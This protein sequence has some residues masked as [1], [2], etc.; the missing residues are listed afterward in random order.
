VPVEQ[1][2]IQPDFLWVRAN[3]D[4]IRFHDR[5][6]KPTAILTLTPR[7]SLVFTT[8]GWYSGHGEK[9]HQI[10]LFDGSERLDEARTK[11]RNSPETVIATIR[12]K[13]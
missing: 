11:D 12:G 8:D 6:H 3:G 9:V 7:E 5:K 1:I 13:R 4:L 10:A 2:G